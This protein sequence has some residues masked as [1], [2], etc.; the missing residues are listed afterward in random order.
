MKRTTVYLDESLHRALQLKAIEN[1]H[2][3]L[4]R[5]L[6]KMGKYKI[7]FKKSAFKELENIP[8]P[9]LQKIIKRIQDL[10]ENPL[11]VGCQKLTN[12]DL[13]RIRQG[14]Y[15]IVYLIDNKKSELKIFKIGHRKEIYRF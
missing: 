7:S 11:P 4:S 1:H 12:Y 3:V 6:R 10:K 5:S 15:R 9:N 2:S 8:K 13:Y 14:D